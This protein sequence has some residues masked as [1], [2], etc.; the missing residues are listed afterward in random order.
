MTG[1]PLDAFLG[2]HEDELVAFRRD[3][4]QHPELGRQEHRTTD[5]LM[6]RLTKSGLV[7]RR[8][9]GGTGVVCDLGPAAGPL[10]ALRADIDAL[11]VQDVKDVPYR[12]VVPGVCHAC[13]HDVHAAVVLGAGLALH[14]MAADLP[15]RVRLVFQAA[16]EVMPGGALDAISD[17]VLD[18]V[19]SIYGLHC[20]PHI[21]VGAVG[22]R[23]GPLTAACDLVDVTLRGP[24]GHT[25]RPHLTS[26]V[27]YAAA[28][29]ITDLPAGLS[30]L[31]DPR[32]GMSLVFGSIAG[33]AAA[34]V[35]PREVRLRGTM[36]VLDD[37]AWERAPKVIERLLAA[38][39]ESLG[40]EYELA[41]TR[42]VPPVC[43]EPAA[44]ATMA[45]ATL[46][47]LGGAGVVSTEQSL[48][49]EDFAWYLQ[50][51]PGAMGRLGVRGAEAHG[52]LHSPDFD[53]DEAAI[54]VGVRVLVE[55]ALRALTPS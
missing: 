43:N 17:G 16:E 38:T 15:G 23:T 28:R 8:I 13:G 26:D 7:P 40:V 41:Y 4:H 18:G 52:D 30:R 32:Q 51:V 20:H 19:G 55:T 47:A 53:V 45:A 37:Q 48:G 9:G 21:D 11:P 24:G 25:A 54:G 31:V 29:V 2:H 36:R 49:G 1:A 34:N 33:G 3:L 10:V 42:G 22:M 46:S 44:T 50:R 6:T 27:V 5:L 35:I 12:S 39:V 14:E